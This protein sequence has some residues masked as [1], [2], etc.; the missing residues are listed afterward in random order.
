[1][2]VIREGRKESVGRLKIPLDIEDANVRVVLL[3][4]KHALNTKEVAPLNRN[5]FLDICVVSTPRF[6]M[7]VLSV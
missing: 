2:S 5:F 4:A 3:W 6:H 1:M 7:K